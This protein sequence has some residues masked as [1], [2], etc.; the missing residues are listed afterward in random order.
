M[1]GAAL[2]ALLGLSFFVALVIGAAASLGGEGGQE[3]MTELGH[4]AVG[5]VCSLCALG[6]VALLVIERA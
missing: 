6:I 5:W 1:I 2:I 4:R 3:G